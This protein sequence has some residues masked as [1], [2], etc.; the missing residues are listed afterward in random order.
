VLVLQE[1]TSNPLDIPRFCQETGLAVALDETLDE[2]SVDV[3]KI[4]EM[5]ACQGVVAA[6]TYSVFCF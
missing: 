2:A 4:L 3:E 6:V 1:P 5:Y